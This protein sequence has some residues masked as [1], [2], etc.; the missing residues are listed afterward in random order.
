MKNRI[1]FGLV[2]L[3]LLVLAAEITFGS[4]AVS[5]PGKIIVERG[6]SKEFYFQ[7]QG[8]RSDSDLECGYEIPSIEPFKISFEKEKV[9]VAKGSFSFVKGVIIAPSKVN[10]SNYKYSFCVSCNPKSKESGATMNIRFC[11][12]P[13]E[14][15]VIEE[16]KELKSPKTAMWIYAAIIILAAVLAYIIFSMI[17]KRFF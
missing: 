10:I 9:F 7:I 8:Y 6:S 5:S 3:F 15:G 14:I 2:F 12:V 1:Y 11:G 13:I 16:P 4:Y 17:R